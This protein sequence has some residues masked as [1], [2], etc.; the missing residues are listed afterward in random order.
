MDKPMQRTWN[1]L[2]HSIQFKPVRQGSEANADICDY[3]DLQHSENFLWQCYQLSVKGGE[4][5][6]D[7]AQERVVHQLQFIFDALLEEPTPNNNRHYLSRFF[8]FSRSEHSTT[9][10]TNKL[11]GLYIVGSVGRGKTHLMDLFFKC[12]PIKRKM[13]LHFHRFMQ[14]VHDEL[15]KLDGCTN[16]LKIVAEQFAKDVRVLCLDEMHVNDIAD[17]M[18]LGELFK[19]LFAKNVVLI[20]TSNSKPSELYKD[21]LQRARFLPAIDL[22]EQHT[23]LA[24]LD[25]NTDYRLQK[26]QNQQVYIPSNG[27]ASEHAL[28][29]QFDTLAGIQNHKD[30]T[31]I[32]INHRQIPVKK[33]ADGIAWFDFNELCNT[34]R[35]TQDYIE[36]A[37]YFHTVIISDINVMDDMQ[38]D[39]AKRF[40]NMID[41]FYDHH[42]KLF[43]SAEATPEQ[44]YAGKKLALEFERTQSRLFEMQSETYMASEHVA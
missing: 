20:T 22:L 4:L 14:L 7:V 23:K 36:I 11:T 21:G 17:A 29:Q 12:L 44:L 6:P 37:R 34:P 9:L 5:Q 40:I 8:S 35:S 26:L 15:A 16:P 31:D 3:P 13:R 2:S 25:G 33:W 18:I 32:I 19:Y 38:N 43:F 10:P 41:E 28:K 39:A 27:Q 42:V 30:R 1:D 24:P